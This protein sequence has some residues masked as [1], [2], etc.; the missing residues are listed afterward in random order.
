M[1]KVR[2]CSLC[3]QIQNVN[4]T[5]YLH[6]ISTGSFTGPRYVDNIINK[7]KLGGS[8]RCFEEHQNVHAPSSDN[9]YFSFD[10]LA[11][12]LPVKCIVCLSAQQYITQ[13]I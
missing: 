3:E 5:Y 8:Y 12:R 11:V 10:M 6:V 7:K 9:H 2:A 4:K 1:T 13:A